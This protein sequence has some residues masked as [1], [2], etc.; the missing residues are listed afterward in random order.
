MLPWV[1][2]AVGDG[3]MLLSSTKGNLQRPELIELRR[4][5]AKTGGW[6][7][8]SFPSTNLYNGQTSSGELADGA[9]ETPPALP[10]RYPGDFIRERA[11]Y[12]G[13]SLPIPV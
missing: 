12:F 7:H 11:S 1:F 2:I 9:Q 4:C 3:L 5:R 6:L 13:Q 10:F 8:L